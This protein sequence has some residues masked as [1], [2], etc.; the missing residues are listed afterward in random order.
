MNYLILKPIK[1]KMKSKIIIF[2]ICTA[3]LF[4]SCITKK[5]TLYV[6]TKKLPFKIESGFPFEP[7]IK[8]D[9]ILNIIVTA[10]NPEAAAVFNLVTSNRNANSENTISQGNSVTYLVD[11][12]GFIEMPVLGRFKVEGLKKS[13]LEDLLKEKISKIVDNPVVIVRIL[14]YRLYVVGEVN[15]SG[16]QRLDNGERVTIFEAISRAGDLTINGNRKKIRILRENDGVQTLNVIDITKPD[17]I[18][19]DFYFLQQND[20]VIVDPNSTKITTS[21]IG[22][23]AT[24]MSIITSAIS[25]YLLIDRF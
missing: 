2:F 13:E 15:R 24:A 20:V 23:F 17:F 8:S 5:N 22:P 25:L 1:L 19:S 6:Q 4:Q 10:D 16:E 9:N 14:N 11:Y 12:K 21:S 7:K 18:N 3:L